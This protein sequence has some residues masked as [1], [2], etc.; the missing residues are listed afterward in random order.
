[1]GL[2]VAKTLSNARV[3]PLMV[4]AAAGHNTVLALDVFLVQV[5]D[6]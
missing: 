5:G 2:L 3:N 6:C 1:V 4:S